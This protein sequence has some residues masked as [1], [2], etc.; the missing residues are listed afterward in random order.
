MS[1][2][3]GFTLIEVTLF[4]GVTAALFLGVAL[5]MGNAIDQQKYNDSVQSFAEYLRGIY[6]MVSNPQS[7]GQ[8]NSE[9]A[10]YGRLIVFGEK[11]DFAGKDITDYD[12]RPVFSYDVIG[13][14]E[15]PYGAT[16]TVSQIMSSLN[17]NVVRTPKDA[18]GRI[19]TVELAQP[20]QFSLRWETDVQN[21][22]GSVFSGS[23]LIVRHPRSGTIN[24]LVMPG[25]VIDVNK[26]ALQAKGAYESGHS[27]PAIT[28]LL[29]KYL[30]DSPGSAKFKTDELNFCISPYNRGESGGIPRQNIRLIKN[31][32]NA[33]GVVM[34]ETDGGDNKCTTR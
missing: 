27:Y 12:G 32:R 23:I 13:D 9:T 29:K 4:L 21:I 20:E 19:T 26:E 7:G 28:E 1:K 34:I 2:R 30:D 24:T 25:T 14:V 31:S 22:D 17:V 15:P 10:I 5:S 16:G 8:G 33:S 18:R 3:K 6:S 11:T